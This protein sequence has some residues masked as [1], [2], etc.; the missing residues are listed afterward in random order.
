MNKTFL[1]FIL[2]VA[3]MNLRAQNVSVSHS[4]KITS[5]AGEAQ[6]TVVPPNKKSQCK[7]G[8]ILISNDQLHPPASVVLGNNLDQPGGPIIQSKFDLGL[9]NGHFDKE[10]TK[11]KYLLSGTSD[12]DL[13]TLS[14]GDVLYIT[15]AFST[16]PVWPP[17]THA[18]APGWFADTFRCTEQEDLTCLSNK[19]FGPGARSVVLVFR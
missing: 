3:A 7:E 13:V 8:R 17:V 9:I 1:I 18:K 19:A 4:I 11:T 12:H 2:L 14:N 6:S 15:G 5:N 10:L 16:M